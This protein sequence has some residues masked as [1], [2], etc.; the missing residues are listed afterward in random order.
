MQITNKQ[1]PHVIDRFI[2]E[3]R[4]LSNF[5]PV[6]VNYDQAEY[7][8]VEHAYVAGKTADLELRKEIASCETPGKAKM[9]GRTLEIRTDLH[10]DSYKFSHM[11]CLVSQKFDRTKNPELREMLVSTYPKDLVEGNYHGDEYW[12][13]NLKKDNRPGKNNLGKILM[14]IRDYDPEGIFA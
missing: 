5:W 4:F 6:V 1:P 11:S 3:Y 13:V 2:N 14:A 7:P 10:W 12:G 9:L 8:S